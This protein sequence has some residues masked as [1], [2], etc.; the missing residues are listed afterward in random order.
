MGALTFDALLRSLKQEGRAPA[1]TYYLHGDEDVLKD[2]AVREVIARALDPAARDFNLDVRDAAELDPAQFRALVDTPPMLAHRRVVVLREATGG[3]LGTRAREL[4][5]L[6]AVAAGRAA[7][8]DDVTALVGVRRGETLS[9]LVDAALARRG[10]AASRLVEPV[11]AQAGMSGV[12][13][14]TAVGTALLGTALAPAGPERRT[15]R[16]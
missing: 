4:E 12:R 6:A 9:D 14:A 1:P 5:K 3:E 16:A 15:P 7:T 10:A 2:E 13:I 8:R 11:L